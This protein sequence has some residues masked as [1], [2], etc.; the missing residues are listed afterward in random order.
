MRNKIW[1]YMSLPIFCPTSIFYIAERI[2]SASYLAEH[3]HG[4]RV[5]SLEI[6]SSRMP[7]IITTY[8]INLR[9]LSEGGQYQNAFS[10]YKTN[11]DLIWIR[12]TCSTSNWVSLITGTITFKFNY[13]VS[14]NTW[15]HLKIPNYG[16][17]KPIEVKVI[18][19]IGFSVWPYTFAIT[20]LM[21]LWK[22]LL[23]S[24]NWILIS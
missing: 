9:F 15:N 20:H 5:P 24:K 12:W 10:K 8:Q 7:E 4:C 22:R 14:C 1:R 23:V 2:F 19:T 6:F 3:T 21:N 11:Y 13:L 17:L 16:S 18:H